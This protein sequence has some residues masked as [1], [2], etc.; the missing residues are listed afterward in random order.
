MVKEKL[1]K[2][3]SCIHHLAIH[4]SLEWESILSIKHPI[5]WHIKFF[6]LP[7]MLLITLTNF[8]GYL[9]LAITVKNFSI[10]YAI[11]KTIAVVFES[12]FPFY[13]GSLII[14]PIAKKLKLDIELD[15]LQLL[16]IYSSSV[17]WAAKIL[18]GVLANYPTLSAFIIFLGIYGVYIF[19]VGAE[20]MK[21]GNS[22]I[23]TKFTA[24]STGIY[25]LIYEIIRWS[26]SFPLRALHYA[27]I[28]QQ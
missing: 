21:V 7:I 18:A 5:N 14:E 3:F 10:S 26:F 11:V 23:I 19:M 12:F 27:Y 1:K 2:I 17:F 24:I 15:S 9:I 6:V 25:I 13:I 4:P 20:K 28:F 16:L 22:L 8:L